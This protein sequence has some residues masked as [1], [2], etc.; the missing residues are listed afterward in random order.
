MVEDAA[1]S[2]DRQSVVF[3]ANYG[4]TPGDDDRRHI[5]RAYPGTGV[6]ITSG[7]S[8]EFQPVA[9]PAM[10]LRSTSPPRSSRCW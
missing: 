1:V 7:T 9:W 6:P 3:S 2:P 8:S 4:S 10:P 5:F